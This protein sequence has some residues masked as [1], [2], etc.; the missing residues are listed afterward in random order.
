MYQYDPSKSMIITNGTE[1]LIDFICQHK[2]DGS[3]IP[4]RI[5]LRDEDGEPQEYTVRGYRDVSAYGHVSLECK[6]LVR[7]TIKMVTVFSGD[8]KLWKIKK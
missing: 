7:D 3:I 2:T 8:C 1:N 4:L 5:R 6:I